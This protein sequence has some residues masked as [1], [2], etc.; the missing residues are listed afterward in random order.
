MK[1]SGTLLDLPVVDEL[2]GACDA[3]SSADT[4]AG[5]RLGD[6]DVESGLSLLVRL[7]SSV[8]AVQ[9]V[10]LAE[11]ESR[12]LKAATGAP[13]TERWL[14]ERLHLSRAEGGTRLRQSVALRRCP[15]VL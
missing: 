13:S 7:Q 6:G 10:L 1:S 15:I 14:A 2:A 4:S 5:W 9:A 11:A 3:L 8:A 12:N